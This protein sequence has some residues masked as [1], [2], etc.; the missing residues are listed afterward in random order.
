MHAWLTKALLQ[1]WLHTHTHTETHGRVNRLTYPYNV[2][3]NNVKV[4]W[5]I[6]PCFL[7]AKEKN[8]RQKYAKRSIFTYKML[9]T[10]ISINKILI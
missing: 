1:H 6:K 5:G 3:F 4:P 9:K 2:N 10:Q 7:I 8:N